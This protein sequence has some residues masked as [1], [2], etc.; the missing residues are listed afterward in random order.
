MIRKF[1]VSLLV[2]IFINYAVFIVLIFNLD[3]TYLN[4]RFYYGQVSEKIAQLLISSN[5]S[6]VYTENTDTNNKS[7]ISKEE[8]AELLKVV[9]SPD[10][11]YLTIQDVLKKLKT[12]DLNEKFAISFNYIKENSHV[13]TENFAKKL[14]EKMPKCEIQSVNTEQNCIPKGADKKEVIEKLQQDIEKQMFDYLPA[15]IVIDESPTTKEF[16]QYLSLVYNDLSII[17]IF[18]VSS[19]IFML[20]V[21]AL[22]LFRPL[23]T[24][25]HWEGHTLLF[26]GITLIITAFSVQRLILTTNS[27]NPYITKEMTDTISFFSQFLINDFYFA[28]TSLVIPGLLLY[29]TS[30]LLKANINRI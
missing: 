18:L 30:F 23:K 28:G 6:A 26:S 13:F 12:Y 11:V 15:E 20:I 5:T 9:F 21:I 17:K 2:L 8:F 16:L 24:I 3:R 22:I 10:F 25:A 19:A 4:E 29:L 14:L 27:I 7:P 1:I